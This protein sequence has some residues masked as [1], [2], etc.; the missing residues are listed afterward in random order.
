[1]LAEQGVDARVASGYEG[2][3]TLGR[4]ARFTRELRAVIREERPA[5]VWAMGIKAAILSAAAGRL[6]RV[7][8]VW[9]KVDFSYDSTLARPTAAAVKGV[10]GVSDAVLSGLGPLRRRRL[11]VVSPPVTLP[12]SIR[13]APDREPHRIGMLG[14]LTEYKGIDRVIRAAALLRAEY[15]D[16]RLTVAGEEPDPPSGYRETLLALASELGLADAVEFPGFVEPGALLPRLDALVNATHVDERG[17]GLEGL[18]GAMLEASWVGVPVVATRGGGT[19]EGLID[20]ITGTLVERP[21]P[22]LLATAI[23]RYLGDRELNERTG[24]AG[25][26]LARNRC[27]PVANSRRLFDLLRGAA[28]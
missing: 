28:A 8:V 7:P 15:P 19:A 18:S 14:R 22:E 10:I 3:P 17:F 11:G 9:H 21:D 6:S 5:V 27:E 2:R 13:R 23:G 16:L 26:G 4:V 12:D 25:R 20:G 24:E 1:M